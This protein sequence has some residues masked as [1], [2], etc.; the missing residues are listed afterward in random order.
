MFL[1]IGCVTLF[2][3]KLPSHKGKDG[4]GTTQPVQ[5]KI[6]MGA[7]RSPLRG[8][9]EFNA[10]PFPEPD[11]IHRTVPAEV[12]A[13]RRT[14][15]AKGDRLPE[16]PQFGFV[17]PCAA[18]LAPTALRFFGTEAPYPIPKKLKTG[19]AEPGECSGP[20]P[21]PTEP[22]SPEMARY[23]TTPLMS[24]EMARY[25]TTPL[26]KLFS[27]QHDTL[28]ARISGSS[29][30]DWQQLSGASPELGKMLDKDTRLTDADRVAIVI[31]MLYEPNSSLQKESLGDF[32]GRVVEQ[33]LAEKAK[34][35]TPEK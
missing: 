24:P 1:N 19:S 15:E 23:L 27:L 31:R 18:P 3:D 29:P 13:M 2:G 21:S 34:T 6:P 30:S 26:S 22:M 9:G 28:L 25:L 33:Y 11:P 32:V 17:N 7:Q 4:K 14:P 8:Y 5:P 10:L 16:T 35:P 12:L 20:A